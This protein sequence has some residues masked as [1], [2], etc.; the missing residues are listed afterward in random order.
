MI[1]LSVLDQ[2]PVSEGSSPAEALAQTAALAQ[3]AERLGYFRFWVAE[4]HFAPGLA[5]SSPEVLMAH[6]AAVTSSIRIGSGGILLPHY[7]AY[8]VAENFRVLQAL[9]PGRIDLGIGRAAGGGVLA[10][11]ALQEYGKAGPDHYSLQIADLI[12]YLNN[13]ADLHHRF[14]GL[15]AMPVVA[16]PPEIWLLGSSRDSAELAARLGTGLAFAH[17][18]NFSE[19]EAAMAAYRAHFCPS[20]L[21]LKPQGMVA[22]FAACAETAEEAD[23]LASSMDLSAVLLDKTHVSTPTPSVES[24]LSY[25]YTPYEKHIVNENRKHILVGSPEEIRD[26]LLEICARFGCEEVIIASVMHDFSDKLKSYR[27]IAEACG[28]AGRQSPS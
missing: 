13:G 7:S 19:G 1:K 14:A 21:L 6:L 22:V 27:L 25:P 10:V 23:R 15:Q 5:G 8:K 2:S 3:E 17:F 18:I 12:A 26:Q 28:L 9:Y 11:R 4:H 24:A 20:P 16:S